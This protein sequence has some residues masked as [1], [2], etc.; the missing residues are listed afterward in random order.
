M[1]RR[2]HH[3]DVLIV[4]GGPAGLL[5]A[6]KLGKHLDVCLVDRHRV[7]QTSKFW[8]TTDARLARHDLLAAA[9]YRTT[10]ATIGT[11]QGPVAEAHGNFT[12]VDERTLLALLVERCVEA[13][14]RLVEDTKVLS[15]ARADGRQVASTT[16]G[17]FHARVV[18]DASGG[19]SPFAATFRLHRLEGFYSIYGAHLRDLDLAT[20]DVVGA[21]IVHF[22]HPAPLFEVIP[23]GPTSAFCVV[24][25]ASRTVVAPTTL[26]A[27]FQ[28]H[29][30]HNPFFV[31]R[32]S[33]GVLDVK[34]GVIPIGSGCGRAPR[35]ILPVGEAGMLQSPLL[36]AAFNEI[37]E[38]GDHI[39]D[40]VRDAFRAGR[41]GIVHPRVTFP[42][43]KAVNDRVQLLLARRLLE[44]TLASFERLVQFMKILGP[45]RSYRMFC[46]KLGWVDL[47]FVMSAALH[48]RR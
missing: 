33:G 6:G 25:L 32:R 30:A 43:I 19:A 8:L 45:V 11:F 22:G 40:K 17:Q 7:G 44:G 26:S 20:G 13:S 37:L 46:T 15:V 24:F 12:T 5:L 41:D 29:V 36:G 28:E 1:S 48:G 34:M 3:S 21:H 2:V 14:V 31:P 27:L 42:A 9:Q 23:T 10:N 47:P 35:G 38:Y 39:V 4:G 18:L 16:R